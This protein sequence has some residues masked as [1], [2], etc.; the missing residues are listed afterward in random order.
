MLAIAPS[1]GSAE[2][3]SGQHDDE[4]FHIWRFWLANA[5]KG[6][7]LHTGKKADE[8]FRAR[9]ERHASCDCLFLYQGE[10]HFVAARIIILLVI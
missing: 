3:L 9:D 5:L 1:A 4:L 8:L 2:R 10:M 6:G 7:K